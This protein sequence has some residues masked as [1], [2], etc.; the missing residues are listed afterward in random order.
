MVHRLGDKVLFFGDEIKYSRRVV[1]IARFSIK[2]DDPYTEELASLGAY[3][4]GGEL[5]G[6]GIVNDNIFTVSSIISIS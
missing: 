5:L 4:L 1:E 6:R 2:L 3:E